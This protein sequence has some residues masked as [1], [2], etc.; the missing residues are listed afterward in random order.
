[1]VGALLGLKMATLERI[2]NKEHDVRSCLL[3]MLSQLSKQQIDPPPTWAALAEAVEEVDP[4]IAKHIRNKH[5]NKD[6]PLP[7]L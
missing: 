2:Q 1:M 4:S 6:E 3:A 7:Q 5:S